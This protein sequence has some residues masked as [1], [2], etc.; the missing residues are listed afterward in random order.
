MLRLT[1]RDPDLSQ[2]YERT[3]PDDADRDYELTRLAGTAHELDPAGNKAYL[4][5]DVRLREVALAYG[6]SETV[7]EV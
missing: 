1:Y 2:A 4:A 6:R 7:E 3:V 5:D